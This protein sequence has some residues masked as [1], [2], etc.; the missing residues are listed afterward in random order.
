AAIAPQLEPEPEA[1]TALGAGAWTLSWTCLDGC[2]PL[3]F[4]PR[5]FT[6]L[7]VVAADDGGGTLDLTF[8]ATGAAIELA[9]AAELDGACVA[10]AP[11]SF[12]TG[13]TGEVRFCPGAHGPRA[14]VTFSPTSGPAVPRT[15]RA[16][17]RAW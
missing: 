10:A 8:W 3:P 2:G 1:P 5:S 9:V 13:T 4:P 16:D 12:E 11:L 14:E 7:D 6:D 17:A 15:Y